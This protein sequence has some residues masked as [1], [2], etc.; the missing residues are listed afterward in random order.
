MEEGCSYEDAVKQTQ[1][2]G[3]AETDP[4]GDLEGWDAAVKLAALVTVIYDYPIIPTQVNRQGITHVTPQMIDD[5]WQRGERLKLVCEAHRSD[6]GIIATVGLQCVPPSSLLYT[7]N[8]GTTYLQFE[9][10]TLPVL[11]IT[12][13]GEASAHTTAYGLLTDLIEIMKGS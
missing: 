8:E 7:I 9:T 12:E 2:M 5:A 4:S 10:D 13:A 3:I 1:E 6:G 11:G